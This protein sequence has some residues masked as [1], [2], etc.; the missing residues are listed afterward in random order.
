MVRTPTSVQLL[1]DGNIKFDAGTMFGSIPKMTWESKVSTDRKNRIV[2]GINCLL[3]QICGKNVLIDTG[4]GSKELNDE[5]ETFGLGRSR[6]L[7][8]LKHCGLSPKFIDAVI[9]T[10]LHFDHSGGCTRL[11][12]TGRAIPTFRNATYM[13]QRECWENVSTPDEWCRNIHR[14][15]DYEPIKDQLVLLDGDQEVFPGLSV[16]MTG[17]HS[18]GHQ[19]VLVECGGE[20]IAFLGT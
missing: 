14:A 2:L 1:H 4:V 17:G 12:P 20:K 11:D 7:I 18:I 19:I 13:V 5:K 16:K 8:E 10:H 9:L 6:L 15:Q 3:V